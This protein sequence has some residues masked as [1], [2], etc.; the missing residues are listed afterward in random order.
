MA[1]ENDREH[2]LD[3]SDLAP[4]R[5]QVRLPNGEITGMLGATEITLEQRARVG[6][7][8]NKIDKVAE[9]ANPT[10][11]QIAQLESALRDLARIALPETAD[12][13]IDAF[14][15]HQLDL[16]TGRFLM[17]FGETTA[18]TAKAIGGEKLMQLIQASLSPDSSKPTEATQQG[19]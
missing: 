8:H 15:P 1:T 14:T 13:V 9:A 12:D 5:E 2:I 18:A 19:G 10:K 16:V 7:L 6:V 4:E 3:L 11:N 17:A